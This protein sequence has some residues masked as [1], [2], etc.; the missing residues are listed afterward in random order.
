MTAPETMLS[1]IVAS[2]NQLN[3]LKFTLLSLKDQQPDLPWELIVVE[4]SGDPE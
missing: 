3:A 2:C 4:T 1:V